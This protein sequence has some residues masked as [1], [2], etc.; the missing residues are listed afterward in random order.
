VLIDRENFFEIPIHV[1][2]PEGS[3][4]GSAAVLLITGLV[5]A[6]LSATLF[7]RKNVGEIC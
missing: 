7:S 5:T 4:A 2:T 6:L 1:D 3:I